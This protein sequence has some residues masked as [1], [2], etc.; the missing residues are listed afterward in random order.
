MHTP[1]R[2]FSVSLS[3][4]FVHLIFLLYP[5]FISALV[6]P[7]SVCLSLFFPP[8]IFSSFFGLVHVP[9]RPFP[10]CHVFPANACTPAPLFLFAPLF[11]IGDARIFVSSV[12]L[13]RHNLRVHRLF[14]PASSNPIPQPHLFS[15]ELHTCTVFSI[16]ADITLFEFSFLYFYFRLY[17]IFPSFLFSSCC[18][19]RRSW[20]PVNLWNT[21]ILFTYRDANKMFFLG[22]RFFLLQNI[23]VQFR[24]SADIYKQRPSRGFSINVIPRAWSEFISRSSP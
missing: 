12:P 24:C 22:N 4:F 6:L 18:A 16:M 2:F 5:P 21:G 10:H 19:P 7:L 11:S 9:H 3:P 14:V 15:T 20:P 23:T 17:F 1:H 13:S 8:S